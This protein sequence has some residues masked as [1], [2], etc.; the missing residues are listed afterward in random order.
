V[1][2]DFM[3]GEHKTPAHFARQPF[4][5]MPAMEDGDFKLFE[6]RA[7]IRYI[8]ETLPGQALTPKDAKTRAHMNQWMCVEVEDLTPPMM[9]CVAQ[10]MFIPMRG[11]KTDTAKVEEAKTKLATVLAVLDKH[12]ASSGPHLVGDAFTLADVSYMPYLE[13]GVKTSAK[14]L[15]LGHANVAAWWKRISERPTWKHV[16]AS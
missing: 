4:G 6:S 7:M 14:D 8:D 1:T 15:I 11:G 12:L 5:Q 10:E 3:K 13:Y 9:S 16:I 2:I